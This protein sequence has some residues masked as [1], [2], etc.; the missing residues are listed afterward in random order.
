MA[1]RT[2]C[3]V[4]G[5]T[6]AVGRSGKCIRCYTLEHRPKWR[7]EREALAADEP[8]ATVPDRQSQLRTMPYSE[9]L[10]TPEWRRVREGALRRAGYRCQLCSADDERDELDVHHN[11]YRNRGAEEA[12]DLVVLCRPCHDYHHGRM[13]A[14]K[15]RWDPLTDPA[16]TYTQQRAKAHAHARAKARAQKTREAEGFKPW[17]W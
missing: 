7:A 6:E 12:R 2:P 17:W 3:L 9:Y 4:C 1:E 16:F 11:T 10:E 5:S 15:R 8:Q 13:D 14:A